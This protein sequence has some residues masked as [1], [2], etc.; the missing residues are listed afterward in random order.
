MTCEERGP[1]LNALLDGELPAAEAAALTAHLAE[2]PVCTRHLAGLAQ[3]RAGLAALVPEEAAPAALRRRI[4]AMIG[5]AE[6]PAPV[7][8]VRPG[9]RRWFVAGVGAAAFAAILALAW[10]PRK[11]EAPVIAGVRDAVLRAG[12]PAR[13]GAAPGWP[14]VP[15]PDLASAGFH[16]QSARPDA[17][18]GRKAVVLLYLAGRRRVVLCVWQTNE[19]AHPPRSAADHGI[20]IRYWTDG[21]LDFWAATRAPASLLTRFVA[22]YR[23][24]A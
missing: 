1:A 13:I 14:L 19:A 11:N 3:V 16:L 18:A 8:A 2:C 17:I 23:R 4:E 6:P 5:A 9:R 7:R 10:L 22:A 21:R 24:G 12:L 20:A 15:E